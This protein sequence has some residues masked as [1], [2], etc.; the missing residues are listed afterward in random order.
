MCPEFSPCIFWRALKLV[1]KSTTLR[2]LWRRF[3]YKNIF[4]WES[5]RTLD[6]QRI[7]ALLQSNTDHDDSINHH[8]FDRKARRKLKKEAHRADQMFMVYNFLVANS[9][10]NFEAPKLITCRRSTRNVELEFRET[11]RDL[12]LASGVLISYLDA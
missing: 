7:T 11:W 5:N 2:W 1:S 12:V 8:A 3:N 6:E 4:A 10:M 9:Y